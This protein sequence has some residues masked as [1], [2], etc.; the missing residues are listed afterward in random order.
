MKRG[1]LLSIVSWCLVIP[2]FELT[3]QPPDTLQYRIITTGNTADLQLEEDAFYN[4]LRSMISSTTTPTAIIINGDFTIGDMNLLVDS[5]KVTRLVSVVK[6]L[7]HATLIVLPGDRDW[8]DSSPEGWKY[9]QKL[10]RMFNRFD[11]PNLHWPV[12]RGCPGPEEIFLGEQVLLI[13]LQTQWWNHP[14]SKPT[15]GDAD[16]K[17]ADITSFNEELEDLIDEN[18][19][20]NIVL[21][22][23]FPILSY[24]PYGG[25]WPWYK[26]LFPIPVLSGLAPAFHSNV[27]SVKDI[28]N[29]RFS[30]LKEKLKSVMNEQ[31]QLIYLSSHEQ[32]LQVLKYEDHYLIN[33]GSPVKAGYS[34]SGKL[35]LYSESNAGLVELKYF[36][37]GRVD[38]VIYANRENGFVETETIALYGARCQQSKQVPANLRGGSCLN[39]REIN[40]EEKELPDTV[41]I[42]AGE[43]YQAGK[44]KEAWFGK[45]Y[46]DSWTTRVN[47]PYLNLD[48]TFLG[49]TPYQKGGGRQT[50]SLKFIAGNGGEYVFRSVNKDPTRALDYEYRETI[51]GTIVRDQTSSQQPYG[52][53]AADKLLD[54]LGILHASP[55]LYVL[56][57]DNR[58]NVFEEDYTGLLGMLEERPTNPKKVEKPFAEADD[59][60]KSYEMFLELYEDHK[61]KVQ[62]V[63]FARA[64]V[65]D[66]LVGDWGKHEDNWKWAEYDQAGGKIFRPIPRDRD[67]VFSLWDG[68]LPWIADREWAKPSAANFGYEYKGIKS[69]MW[70]GRHLDRFLANELDREDWTAAARFIQENIDQHDIEEAV[71]NMPEE[72]YEKDGKIIG[73]KLDQRLSSLHR[74]ASSYYDLLAKEVDVVGSNK[75]EVFK[76]HRHQNGIVE[77]T[78]R[79]PDSTS[80]QKDSSGIYYYRRFIPEETREIRLFGLQEA[81]RFYITGE[82]KKSI[83]IRIIG[84]P[85]TDLIVDR[86]SV[87]GLGKMTKVYEKDMDAA[88]EMGSS[89]RLVNHW[90][91]EVF[92]YNRTAFKYNTYLPL[93]FIFYS[94]DFG[95]GARM[96]V[97]FTRQRFAKQDYASKHAVQ[98]TVSSENINVL[99]YKGELHHILGRWDLL[100]NALAGDHFYF[101]YFFGI[102]NDTEKDDELFDED[103]YQTNYNSYQLTA[104]LKHEMW[105]GNKSEVAFRLHYENNTGQFGDNTIINDPELP[106]DILGVDDTNILAGIFDLD[107]DFRDR[108]S[109][110]E[111][112][113]RI[114][115]QH[116][117]G[118]VSS[119]D[120]KGYGVTKASLEGFVS[121]YLK[122]PVTIGLKVGGSKSYG[123]VPFYKLKYLGQGND[124]RGYLG[125]RFTGESTMFLNTELR[126]ELSEFHTSFFPLRVG[127]KAFFDTGRVYSPYDL[128]NNWHHGYGGGFYL[129]PLKEEVSFNLS[130]AFSEEESGLLLFGIGKTF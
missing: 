84:G 125:N 103:Y 51:I 12:N 69:L 106:K 60:M 55:T 97:Q 81:D 76:V 54:N 129:I 23:H 6:G 68:V 1:L 36:D 126:W 104:G 48:T 80:Q 10:E 59:I 88:S 89:A 108:S 75:P 100:L 3:A 66:L 46:R 73:E 18:D 39:T 112:G 33:S 42:A 34:G 8:A 91:E 92:N 52:A 82:A 31:H 78:M 83:P 116:Q 4:N 58:M 96:G 105:Y 2:H 72:I 47:I 98:L 32:N 11:L 25:M 13:A 87:G 118:L 102:G 99:D 124:L 115:M 90:D 70:Q 26:Y 41:S 29:H 95:L 123:E 61:N 119:N 122:R 7:D 127:L 40:L 110:P 77:V 53:L 130:L 128:T 27:G 5:I 57:P 74:A 85:G 114:Y 45:H 9:V 19:N 93:A 20:R 15:P 43:E 120:N 67:H 16:C 28:S 50:T 22:G 37:N 121:A 17:I 24:G 62:T 101:T 30:P 111:K 117:S 65:F 71:K 107:L 64:R 63:E 44:V 109:L 35:T 38:A 14:Y 113:L 86:S 21:V 56:P 79:H 94:K 49:L